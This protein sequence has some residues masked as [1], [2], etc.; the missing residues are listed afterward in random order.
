M[1]YVRIFCIVVILVSGIRS[2]FAQ[3]GPDWMEKEA[4]REFAVQIGRFAKETEAETAAA[5]ARNRGHSPVWVNLDG[6]YRLVLVGR[7]ELLPDANARM[8]QLRSAGF[9]TAFCEAFDPK[10]A[11]TG[12]PA[13]YS[14]PNILRPF[15]ENPTGA[16][17]VALQGES[18]DAGS[19]REQLDAGDAS[20]ALVRIQAR[21]AELPES[22]PERGRYELLCGR[23]IIIEKGLAVPSAPYF[24]RVAKGEVAATSSDRSAAQFCYADSLHYYYPS[25]PKAYPAYRQIYAISPIGSPSRVRAGVEL[26]ACLLELSRSGLGTGRGVRNFA[27]DLLKET[28]SEYRR[29]RATVQLILGESYLYD[30]KFSEALAVLTQL[31]EKYP[32][33]LRERAMAALSIALVKSELGDWPGARVALES[34]I[35]APLD[36]TT[37][38]FF[39]KGKFGDL[40]AEALKALEFHAVKHG[41]RELAQ[42]I[43]SLR[44]STVRSVP[45]E[46]RRGTPN[47]ID[48]AFPHSMYGEATTTESSPK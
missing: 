47:A 32:T 23:A 28:P 18:S 27:R 29:A 21:L 36:R 9:P 1:L 2:P 4:G 15:G 44:T 31:T 26:T 20:G 34:V 30:K 10:L 19:I 17:G 39:W 24:L 11:G 8:R 33:S 3:S 7:Y 6:D 42:A 16:A 5:D 45:P 37:D 13:A 22:H 41:D 43:P 46:G 35:N 48:L 12:L 38:Q 25:A 40:R 14:D